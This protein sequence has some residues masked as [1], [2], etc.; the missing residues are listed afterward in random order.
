MVWGKALLWAIYLQ[1]R[2]WGLFPEVPMRGISWRIRCKCRNW[3]STLTVV[4]V[5]ASARV[6]TAEALSATAEALSA[7]AE[8]LSAA[9]E[10]LSAATETLF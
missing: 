1:H 7:T 10:T 3:K 6:A 2:V 5:T 9:T 4:S 8:A